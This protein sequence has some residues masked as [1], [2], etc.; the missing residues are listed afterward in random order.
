MDFYGTFDRHVTK[1]GTVSLAWMGQAGFLLKN[2]TGKVLVLD[3]YL[4]DL[5]EKQDGNKRLMPAL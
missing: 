1:K 5:S 3:V 2:S 4:S